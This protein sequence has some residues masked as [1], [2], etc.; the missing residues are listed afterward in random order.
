MTFD[1]RTLRRC[2][3]DG[4][5]LGK[6]N[7][8]VVFASSAANLEN[9]GS[10]AYY[11]V[12]DDNNVIVT[13][14]SNGWKSYGQISESGN[15]SEY[16]SPRGYHVMSEE[17]AAMNP[18][19]KPFT[20]SASGEDK[21]PYVPGYS[22]DERPVGDVKATIDVEKT[23]KMARDMTVESLLEGFL[24]GVDFSVAKG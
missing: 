18:G 20:S 10:G 8:T 6:W 5:R 2:E 13:K 24:P 19:R 16:S 22:V 11:I 1:Y 21:N 4:S 12:Y 9:K 7:G 15:I 23:L 17:V 3:Y 14:T